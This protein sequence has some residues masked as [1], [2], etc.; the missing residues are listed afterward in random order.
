MPALRVMGGETGIALPARRDRPDQHAIIDVVPGDAGAELRDDAD[1]LMA[2]DQPR[3]D[4][5]LT[6]D[7]MQVRPADGGRR[8]PDQ[9]LA[10]PGMRPRNVFHADVAR[11]M[12]HRGAHGP[13]GE[14][15]GFLERGDECCR[16]GG[17]P[18]SSFVATHAGSV[19]G[20]TGG[21]EGGH[22]RDIRGTLG[23]FVPER[24]NR[25]LGNQIAHETQFLIGGGA[26]P[27]RPVGQ[28]QMGARDNPEAA[29]VSLKRPKRRRRTHSLTSSK[30]AT[31]LKP[32]APRTL[33][34]IGLC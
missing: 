8:D 14:G 27:H 22:R 20:G 13:G 2:D 17:P 30:V 15:F 32:C 11:A 33:A 28:N 12:E 18:R 21:G 10:R 4:R 3:P 6:F 25:V 29:D 24:A 31:E 5:I 23:H 1:R 16:H 26:M 19:M 9:R 34:R 7:D